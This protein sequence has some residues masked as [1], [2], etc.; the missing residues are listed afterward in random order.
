[1]PGARLNP[2]LWLRAAA[3]I[4]ALFA[5]GHT[6]GRPWTPVRAP[7]AESVVAAM[8]GVQFQAA[9]AM[10]SY[11]DFYQGFGLIVSL[12]L[13]LEAVLLWQLARAA[14]RGQGYRAAAITH[15][16]AFMVVGAVGALYVFALPM[17]FA[18]AIVL[19]LVLACIAG[20]TRSA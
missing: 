13:A 7:A 15:L 11:W 1:M 5:A 3:V 18:L 20:G 17:W 4:A 2:A 6:A 12:F 8:R 9:G 19:C 10:R 16:V 14:R